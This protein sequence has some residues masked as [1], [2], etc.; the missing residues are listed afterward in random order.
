VAAA[1][2][3]ATEVPGG[4]QTVVEVRVEVEGEP[5]PACVIRSL[6]RWLA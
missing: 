4:V 2:R 5:E 3:E 6:S 1:L